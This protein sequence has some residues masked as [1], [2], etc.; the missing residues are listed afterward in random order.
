VIAEHFIS[1]RAVT[2]AVARPDEDRVPPGRAVMR[3]SGLSR[4]SR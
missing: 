4:R 3:V 1:G 2:Q